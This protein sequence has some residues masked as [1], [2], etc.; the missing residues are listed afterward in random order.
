[1]SKYIIRQ[2]YEFELIYRIEAENQKEALELI[3]D[4]PYEY[5]DFESENDLYEEM[6]GQ[7]IEEEIENEK[8]I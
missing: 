2:K 1:M 5:R 4:D 7:T 8:A 3:A 6:T